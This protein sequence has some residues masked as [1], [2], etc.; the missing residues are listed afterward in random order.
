MNDSELV[1][2]LAKHPPNIRREGTG[3]PSFPVA[4]F[5]GLC[6]VE[7]CDDM[8]VMRRESVCGQFVHYCAF[9]EIVAHQLFG[10]A[11]ERVA[12]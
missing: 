9:H 7:D 4:R 5:D 2:F 3:L 6:A 10:E 12:A 1:R 8:G 11:T